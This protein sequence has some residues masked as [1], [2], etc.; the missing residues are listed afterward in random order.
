[1]ALT[2]L[3]G[4]AAK[5]AGS[6]ELSESVNKLRELFERKLWHDITE[7]LHNAVRQSHWTPLLLELQR[8]F[9]SSFASK[10]NPLAIAKITVDIARR[11]GDP[12]AALALVAGA[13]DTLKQEPRPTPLHT[14]ARMLL[15]CEEVVLRLDAAKATGSLD[16]VKEKATGIIDEAT[17][18]AAKH[19]AQ[20]L[21]V[22]VR[23]H[24]Y[25]AQ[26]SMMQYKAEYNAYYRT[27]LLYLA[28]VRL[29]TDDIPTAEKQKLALNLG[30]AALLGDEIHNFGEF[31]NNPIV[32]SLPEAGYGW[33]LELLRAFNSGDLGSYQKIIVAH[34]AELRSTLGET[35]AGALKMKMQLMALLHHIFITPVHS[36]TFKFKTVADVC[37]TESIDQVEPLVLRALALGLIRGSI[38][39]VDQLIE[40]TWIQ[41][42]V[43]GRSEIGALVGQIKDWSG[44]VQNTIRCVDTALAAQVE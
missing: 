1:M 34:E 16:A 17:E 35:Q 19:E 44:K 42:R 28:H 33:L 36:R 30:I 21:P 13:A 24:I 22:V 40:I 29:D 38:D 31:I 6:P 10:C 15:R 41:S 2:F 23:A 4:V 26:A 12:A 11:N 25:R 43:L 37:N 8:D 3:D 7:E 18:F 39:E 9:I 20:E 32:N 27:C 14:Q 5:S